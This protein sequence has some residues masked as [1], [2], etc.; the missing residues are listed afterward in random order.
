MRWSTGR[1]LASRRQVHRILF[2]DLDLARGGADALFF[3]ADP[4]RAPSAVG[5]GYCGPCALR[6]AMAYQ[7]AIARHRDRDGCFAIL[8]NHGSVRWCSSAIAVDPGRG[9][10]STPDRRTRPQGAAAEWP[11]CARGHGCNRG[12]KVSSEY[13]MRSLLP[14]RFVASGGGRQARRARAYGPRLEIPTTAFIITGVKSGDRVIVW[15]RRRRAP[16]TKTDPRCRRTRTSSRQRRGPP[17]DVVSID[18][19]HGTSIT[20]DFRKRI[21]RAEGASRSVHVTIRRGQRSAPR[22][23]SPRTRRSNYAPKRSSAQASHRRRIFRSQHPAR[24]SASI[25][26]ARFC[27]SGFSRAPFIDMPGSSAR[28]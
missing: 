1:R 22:R 6:I 2:G 20:K 14:R 26:D 16:Q 12:S 9:A 28:G 13:V 18:H 27:R 19:C 15:H 25:G 5:I 24:P 23:C 21:E 10:C 3:G 7:F 4:G 11:L 8:H 17:G